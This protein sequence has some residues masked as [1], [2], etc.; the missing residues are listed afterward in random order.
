MAMH[1]CE[2][3]DK[4]GKVNYCKDSLAIKIKKEWCLNE[5]NYE[6]FWLLK[7]A[8]RMYYSSILRIKKEE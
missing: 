4:L 3:Y 2:K 6:V 5:Y 1:L 7:W 8:K